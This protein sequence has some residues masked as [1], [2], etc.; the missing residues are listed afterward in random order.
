MKDFVTRVKKIIRSIMYFDDTSIEVID[1]FSPVLAH[2]LSLEGEEFL[3]ASFVDDVGLDSL[4]AIELIMA[5]EEEFDISISDE[6]VM[7]I[8]QIKDLKKCV[9]SKKRGDSKWEEYIQ[10]LL[11]TDGT[12]SHG[13]NLAFS[14]PV[15]AP[16]QI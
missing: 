5:V 9:D 2:V 1:E 14:N 12:W 13:R 8:V 15:R 16:F 3:E 11:R 4:E 7:G 10:E 6:D